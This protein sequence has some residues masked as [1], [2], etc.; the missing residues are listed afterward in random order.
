[1]FFVEKTLGQYEIDDVIWSV[2]ETWY[3]HLSNQNA[4]GW[5]PDTKYHEDEIDVRVII[6][7]AE[8]IRQE[9]R[10]KV[11]RN[12]LRN[13]H[14]IRRKQQ[15]NWPLIQIRQFL[16]YL[17]SIVVYNIILSIY[18]IWR[19]WRWISWNSWYVFW[20]F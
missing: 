13:K 6:D 14:F 9:L 15:W 19:K 20:K 5:L 2:L 4:S 3:L 12:D 18:N 10:D 7:Y 17:S 8:A 11:N 16:Q 1:M